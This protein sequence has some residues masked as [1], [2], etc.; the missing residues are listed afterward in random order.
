MLDLPDVM[1]Q[2][3]N[4]MYLQF[5]RNQQPFKKRPNQ[6]LYFPK[7]GSILLKHNIKEF[8]ELKLFYSIIFSSKWDIKLVCALCNVLKWVDS[9]RFF[10]ASL[11][12]NS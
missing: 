11:K 9:P 7:L 8:I 12:P 4:I 3:L 2:V 5:V 1:K 10:W 6:G